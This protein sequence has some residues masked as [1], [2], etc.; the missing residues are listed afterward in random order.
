MK[1]K[2]NLKNKFLDHIRKSSFSHLAKKESTLLVN[3]P[4]IRS[5]LQR[6]TYSIFE[7]P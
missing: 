2:Q 4:E 7:L 6:Q 5:L 3:L 1:Y